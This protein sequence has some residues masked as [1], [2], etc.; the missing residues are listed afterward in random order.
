MKNMTFSCNGT[1][2][3]RQMSRMLFLELF[4][5]GTLI[6]PGPLAK[7]CQNDGIFAI[8]IAA[9]IWAGI[10]RLLMKRQTLRINDEGVEET[11]STH[12]AQQSLLDKSKS[13][14]Q[15]IVFAMAGGFL[16]YLLVS[17]I[18]R[19]LLD[20]NYMWIIVLTVFFAGGY[21]ILKGLESRARIYEI[22]FWILL[23]PLAI[24]L[25][26]A[27]WNVH[28]D[29]WLP[30]FATTLPWF[31]LGIGVCMVAFL[32]AVLCVF[33]RPSCNEPDRVRYMGAK[34]VW[35]AGVGCAC[36]YFLLLGVFQ[37]ELL[38]VLKYPILSLMS[39]VQMPGNLME[40]LDAPMAA[41]WFFCLFAL[42]HSLC[43]YC[44]DGIGKLA[45][46]KKNMARKVWI[47]MV[48]IL[49]S[50][51]FLLLHGCGKK[52]PEDAWYP[53]VI[54]I[55]E[56][57]DTRQMEV[58]YAI[59]ATAAGSGSSNNSDGGSSGNSGGGSSD[60]SGSSSQNAGGASTGGTDFYRT[61]AADSLFQAEERLAEES[62]KVL[63][64]N[65]MKVFI[66]NRELLLDKD[67]KQQLFAYFLEN[68]NMAW[69]TCLLLTEDKMEDLFVDGVSGGS[70]M[71]T[72]IEDLLKNR[73][74]QKMKS[75]FTV[76]DFMSLYQNQTETML[77]PIVSMETGR[78][79]IKEYCIVS[80]CGDRGTL[81]LTD[82]SYA[83]LLLNKQRTL[84]IV[85]AEDAYATLQDI[86]MERKLYEADNGNPKQEII[87]QANLK[88][89]ADWLFDRNEKQQ[90]LTSAKEQVED[91]L[92]QLVT[93]CKEEH[94]ADITNSFL[95]LS[96]Y[97]RKLWR[98]YRDNPDAY[99]KKL[100][101]IV[102]VELKMLDT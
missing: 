83:N 57:K 13:I 60:K 62:E 98:L 100:E 65:H 1:V 77:I 64:L 3:I 92:N 38:S 93:T 52:G 67:Q 73:E 31:L 39:V 55:E 84:S 18:Q 53:L 97:D 89:S 94:H 66:V 5:L 2:S 54:G 8:L 61:I 12:S 69:N 87:I 17:L 102:T 23:I 41:I 37:A 36:V 25:L 27:L 80:R 49:V 4:G 44:V 26:I 19:Q 91:K 88:L 9:A 40:R 42:F 82:S 99:E 95:T 34:V 51:L 46:K 90:V 32:P 45:P 68:E 11:N 24:I 96:G 10:V 101:T 21:G 48:L 7:I 15:V 74:D 76:K 59:P 20:S 85:L 70:S 22:L 14:L 86:R 72:Y 81:S 28:P 35:W 30:I 56:N 47:G 29:Y 33:L 50:S 58:S 75:L 71:G 6:L 16:F 79:E 43:Y 63:D 78:L